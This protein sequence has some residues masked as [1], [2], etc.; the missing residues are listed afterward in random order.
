MQQVLQRHPIYFAI[1]TQCLKSNIVIM[2][3]EDEI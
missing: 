3:H 1:L 2:Q